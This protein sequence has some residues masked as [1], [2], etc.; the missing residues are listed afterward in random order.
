[1]PYL[2]GQYYE[3]Q[4]Q[5]QDIIDSNKPKSSGP[6]GSSR[7]SSG[8]SSYSSGGSS[9]SRPSSGGSSYSSGS[10]GPS[11]TSSGSSSGKISIPGGALGIAGALV[12]GVVG[13]AIKNK[14]PSASGGSSGSYSG[15][16]ASDN[17]DYHQEAI[18]A[19]AQ[20]DWTK[21]S[22]ALAARQAKINAQGGNDR[23]MS[24][25][26]ILASLQNQY[27]NSYNALPS[28][29]QNVLGMAASGQLNGR[30]WEDGRDY[31]ASAMENARRGDLEAAYTDLMRRGFKMYDTGSTGGGTN[32]DQAYALIQRLFDQGPGGAAEYQNRLRQNAQWLAEHPTQFGAGTNPSL[33]GKHF[34]SA[35]GK[36][37]IYYDDTGTPFYAQPYSAASYANKYDQDRL[38]LMQDYYGGTEDYADLRRQL[39]NL[40][41]VRTGNGRL[42]DQDWNWA[43]GAEAVPESAYAWQY[44]PS[45]INQNVGQ[46]KDA[47]ANLLSR[48]NG[49]ERFSSPTQVAYAPIAESQDDLSRSGG[50]AYRAAG[51]PGRASGNGLVSASGLGDYGGQDLTEYIRQMYQQNLQAQLAGLQSSYEQNR[52]AIEAQN[53]QISQNYY[54]QRN[55]AAAQNDLQRMYMAELGNYQGLNTGAS[56]QLAMA[57][58]MALQNGLSTLGAAEN[59]D[60]SNNGLLLN[61]L[62]AGYLGDVNAAQASSG[63]QLAEA[64]YGEYVRQIQAA[65]QAAAAA[66]AQANWQAQFDYQRQQDAADRAF[67]Q[68]QFDYNREQAALDYQYQLAQLEAAANKQNTSNAWDY[69]QLLLKNGVMP[70]EATLYAAGLDAGSAQAL[71]DSYK[72]QLGQKYAP[73]SSGRSSGG[74]TSLKSGMG[75]GSYDA[76][77]QAAQ[78]SPYPDSFIL[79]N[80][81]KYGFSNS[82]GLVDNY[83]DW[84]GNQIHDLADS[85]V[86]PIVQGFL[87]DLRKGYASRQDQV[88]A[89]DK[90]YNNQSN[91]PWMS[92][93][94]YAWLMKKIGV[95]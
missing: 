77:F 44:Q 70:D 78:A 61:Q 38:A 10:S 86:G 28:S 26:Q 24:N 55:Q 89:I 46:D 22:Q 81:K 90:A 40:D 23:G 71:A 3:T 66:Q 14:L 48:V 82:S 17:R 7:P 16:Y 83:W 41:V 65:E 72:W 56:G 87:T 67:S 37:T 50:G 11:K 13:N 21:V 74:D 75:G 4:K 68:Q 35:D 88:A 18:N 76:L 69:A 53:N 34:V 58:G 27:R 79:N 95:S 32:Q 20:G 30:G 92:A 59:Q 43:S 29:V 94:E 80:F 93:D 51:S 47:L 62:Q 54:N 42:I 85:E 63:A 5:R 91:N 25:A 2:N 6:S 1:M 39:H 31:L 9:A 52:A 12:G 19:A 36:Y 60:L 15:G 8:G 49:G 57:Q 73:K 33:A 64:L 84:E 45:N